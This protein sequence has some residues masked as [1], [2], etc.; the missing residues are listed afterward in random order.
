MVDKIGD[1]SM[2]CM[3]ELELD[4]DEDELDDHEVV[5]SNEEDEEMI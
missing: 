2:D 3:L 4:I 5:D 1:D